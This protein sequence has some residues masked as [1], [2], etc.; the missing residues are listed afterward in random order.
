MLIAALLAAAAVAGAQAASVTVVNP[1]F[2]ADFAPDGNFV[3]LYPSG[4]TL[5]DPNG[6]VDFP[7]GNDSVGVLNPT[8]T[9]FFTDPVPHGRNA[10]LVF[11]GSDVGAGEAGLAQTL[12]DTLQANTRYRLSVGIGNI[13][14]GTGLAP[15]DVLGEFNLTGFPGYRVDLLAGGEVIA[16]DNNSLA[17]SLA[18]GRFG[19]SVVEIEIGAV[20]PF[21]GRPLGIRLVNLNLPGTALAPAI[22]VDFDQVTLLATPVPEPA[23][24]AFM[25]AGLATIAQ[26]RGLRRRSGR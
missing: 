8:G 5:Y 19:T 15:Q 12:M 4:W 14:S 26:V 1:S 13:A 21:I 23:T 7:L 2:E 3:L 16:M 18:D 17:G 22:E 9:T 11:L 6:I 25:L 10:A 20:H 24:W